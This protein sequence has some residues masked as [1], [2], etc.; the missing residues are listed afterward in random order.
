[1]L[2][3]GA[4][5]PS[6]P[7]LAGALAFTGR[8]IP[9][10]NL[11]RITVTDNSLKVSWTW[12]IRPGRA[13]AK[14]WKELGI[15]P[16]VWH[17]MPPSGGPAKVAYPESPEFRRPVLLL[18][19]A[20]DA[21]VEVRRDRPS[22]TVFRV[23]RPRSPFSAVTASP[24]PACQCHP[25]HHQRRPMSDLRHA[26]LDP[27][28]MRCDLTP[29]VT[30]FRNQDPRVTPLF[31]DPQSILAAMGTPY[32]LVSGSKETVSIEADDLDR[33][34]DRMAVSLGYVSRQILPPGLVI[35]PRPTGV[36]I[37]SWEGRFEVQVTIKDPDKP[38]AYAYSAR[39]Q[40]SVSLI[41]IQHDDNVT[42]TARAGPNA[43]ARS[44]FIYSLKVPHER[45]PG[46]GAHLDL[47]RKTYHQH[48]LPDRTGFLSVLQLMIEVP[49]SFVPVIGDLYE[50]GQ[51]AFMM[52][53]GRD[54]WGNQVTANDIVLYGTLA[55]VSVGATAYVRLGRSATRLSEEL[56]RLEGLTADLR[57]ILADADGPARSRAF[58][59]RLESLP[60]R[61]QEK[62]VKMLETTIANPRAAPRLAKAVQDVLQE[63]KKASKEAE[64]LLDLD[65]RAMFTED[66]T[67]FSNS[68]LRW[69]YDEYLAWASRNRKDPKAPLD[70]L[71]ATERQWVRGYLTAHLG[72]DYRAVIKAAHGRLPG[73]V[74]LTAAMLRHYDDVA[75]MGINQYNKMQSRV[76]KVSGFGYL[77]ELDHIIEQRFIRRLREWTEA[78]PEY[79]A[80]QA[81]LVPKNAAVAAEMIR[82]DP[83]SHLIRYVHQAKTDMM[84]ALIP[85]GSESLFTAQQVADATLFTLKSLDAHTYLK[86]IDVLE[87]DF[88]FLAEALGQKMPRLRPWDELT[89]DLFTVA[90]G[91]PQA[92]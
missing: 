57:R 61:Q 89:E 15:P 50:L 24:G 49:L 66:M 78:V 92:R 36:V 32:V 11:A 39:C 18:A 82:V 45:V 33:I 34:A 8:L 69:E 56:A 19:L 14:R 55:A 28:T 40:G 51:L 5:Y 1:M 81:F 37:Q 77:F 79:L 10:D 70:W 54:F 85:H 71:L 38:A 88:R 12:T 4:T 6:M 86:T 83:T 84:R 90:N 29:Q 46:Q 43:F 26:V 48:A 42:V 35:V 21:T 17:W 47:D 74:T 87:E 75:G 64:E 13:S 9:S 3:D 59:K 76:R 72:D 30:V 52:A 53:T 31:D 67:S 73:Q 68:M 60:E 65:V 2:R 58:L 27:D 63:T 25:S 44:T 91:W 80:F 7:S 22:F 41:V 62:L 16:V 23:E 20:R